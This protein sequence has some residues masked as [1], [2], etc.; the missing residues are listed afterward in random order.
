[1]S[2]FERIDLILTLALAAFFGTLL[3]VKLTTKEQ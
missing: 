1:M 2:T 3:L